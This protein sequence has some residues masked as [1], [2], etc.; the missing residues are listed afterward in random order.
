MGKL[1]G[2]SV[3]PHG[4]WFFVALIVGTY[5]ARNVVTGSVIESV[6]LAHDI[7]CAKVYYIRLSILRLHAFLFF[8]F[9]DPST[10]CLC[11]DA[12]ISIEQPIDLEDHPTSSCITSSG[13]HTTKIL[14]NQ[15]KMPVTGI[16]ISLHHGLHPRFHEIARKLALKTFQL[17]GITH[18]T[19][20]TVW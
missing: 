4:D 7:D 5:K 14:P 1:A 20:A 6:M 16:F 13:T 3:I 12:N 11:P 15:I 17:P 9:L 18:F 19:K 2:F 8:T 10:G